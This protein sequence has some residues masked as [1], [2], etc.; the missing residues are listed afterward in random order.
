MSFAALDSELVGPLFATGA[1]RDVFSDA[2]RLRAMLAAEAALARAEAR[3]GLVP[4]ELAVAIE[5][6]DSAALDVPEL[7]R[8]TALAGVPTIPFVKAVG[9]MLPPAL[10]PAFHKGSTTQ[11]ILDTALVLQMRDGLALLAADA[12]AVLAGLARLADAHRATPCVGRSYGQQAQPVSF[13]FKVAVWA[14]GIADAAAG[15]PVV[16][17]AVLRASLAGPAGTLAGLGD[18]GPAVADGFA[19]ELELGRSPIG[20]HVRRGGLAALGAWLAILIGALAKMATDVADLASTEVGEAAE[21]HVPGRGGSSAMPHKRNPVSST[22]ILAAHGAAPA[23]ASVLIGAVAAQHERP[24]G[25]WHAEWHALPSLFGLASGAL[26]E[27]KALAEG[28]VPDEARMREN[29]GRTRGLLFAD[30]VAARLAGT[31]GRERAH[32]L[33]ERAAGRVREEGRDLRAILAEDPA[34]AEALGPGGLDDVFDPGPAVRAAAGW[35]D[36]A[37]DAVAA[38]RSALAVGLNER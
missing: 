9:A 15:L 12:D 3:L 16:R 29:L 36:R 14:A 21:P 27:A 24:A 35:I 26:A 30:A 34:V 7:G 25:A 18:H 10:E 37:L 31:L 32:A 19:D 1:M 2:S 11:D 23:F 5:G 8:A 13:G 22:V 33:L 28:L 38:A 6:I 20:W 4:A 17:A